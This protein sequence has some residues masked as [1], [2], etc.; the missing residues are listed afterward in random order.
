MNQL[1]Q[2]P[3]TEFSPPEFF[4]PGLFPAGI[5]PAGIFPA[6]LF[7]ARTFLPLCLLYSLTR[8]RNVTKRLYSIVKELI[9]EEPLT[10]ISDYEKASINALTS[11]FPRVEH[12]GCLFHFARSLYRKVVELGF[13]SQYHNDKSF[14]R[15]KDSVLYSTS[16]PTCSRCYRWI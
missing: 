1:I 16:I 3:Q 8:K 13:K 15:S 2:K 5:F 9:A 11:V 12:Q 14:N 7:P 6:G 10:V 4:P